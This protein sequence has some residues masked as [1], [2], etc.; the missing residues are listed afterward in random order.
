MKRKFTKPSLWLAGAAI[1]LMGVIALS[2]SEAQQANDIRRDEIAPQSAGS[3]LDDLFASPAMSELPVLQDSLVPLNPQVVESVDGPPFQQSRVDRTDGERPHDPLNSLLDNARRGGRPPQGP[4]N[5]AMANARRLQEQ[6]RRATESLRNAEAD[7]QKAN[8]T[9]Y[10]TDLLKEYFD[11]DLSRREK[12]VAQIEE[13]VKNLRA[14]LDRRRQ[15]KQEIIDLQIK[16][17]V[18]EADGLGFFGRPNGPMPGAQDLLD[19]AVP[20]PFEERVANP[21][22]GPVNP[23]PGVQQNQNF[24]QPGPGRPQPQPPRG[25]G[26]REPRGPQGPPP[27]DNPQ[28]QAAQL[29]IPR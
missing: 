23:P 29:M 5:P 6:I 17:A 1:V 22:G 3:P 11:D 25:G 13:R 19:L 15:K 26:R 8:A 7:E 20:G 28:P 4:N 18:N 14:Q 12:E 21:F 2:R 10:L 9:V 27:G 16:V 24:N